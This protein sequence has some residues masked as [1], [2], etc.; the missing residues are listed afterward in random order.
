MIPPHELKN[1]EFTRVMRGYSIPEVD[2][3]ISFVMEKYTDL[4][5]E[6]DALERKL[7]SAMDALDTMRAEEESIRTALI[8]AQKAGK[9]IVADASDRA[10]KIMR[11]TKSDCMRVLTEFRDKAAAERK[12]LLDLKNEV[13]TLKEE[14]FEKYKKHIE[15]LEEL[16]PNAAEE[17]AAMNAVDNDAYA[18][19][20]AESIAGLIREDYDFDI[21]APDQD[22]TSV[23]SARNSEDGG[24]TQVFAKVPEQNP[25]PVHHVTLDDISAPASAERKKQSDTAAD[26]STASAVSE[27]DADALL[28]ALAAEVDEDALVTDEQLQAVYGISSSSAAEP[29]HAASGTKSNS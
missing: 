8:N 26:G 22:D 27:E 2:E 6:N 3:Y 13:T 19:K 16:T 20:I 17:A 25:P 11:S 14:L 5:R 9:Q 7:Q 10:D 12:T 21:T 23:R 1:K 28:E 29:T 18:A 24:D 4:Y 15:Y